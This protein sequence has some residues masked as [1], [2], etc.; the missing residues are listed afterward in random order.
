MKATKMEIDENSYDEFVTRLQTNFPEMFSSQYGGIET[1]PGWWPLIESL[2]S[3]IHHHVKYTNERRATLLEHNPYG[4]EIPDEV[5]PVTVLQV[6]EKFGGLR[7]YTSGGDEFVSGAI[8]MAEAMSVK[9]CEVCGNPGK[10]REGG[11]LK[12]HCDIHTKK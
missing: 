11:W 7:Y 12:T 1:N 4:V 5:E 9:I 3:V 8:R 2:S 10:I 6:K